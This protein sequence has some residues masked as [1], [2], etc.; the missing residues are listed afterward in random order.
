MIC[1]SN[2]LKQGR[3]GVVYLLESMAIKC[4]FSCLIYSFV[5]RVAM[6]NWVTSKPFQ[7]THRH[8]YLRA[9]TERGFTSSR[10]RE[11]EEE[12]NGAFSVWWPTFSRLPVPSL[13]SAHIPKCSVYNFVSWRTR[14]APIR[15]NFLDEAKSLTGRT[16]LFF[17]NSNG[18]WCVSGWYKGR[19]CPSGRHVITYP[20]KQFVC[21]LVF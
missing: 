5:L 4:G 11:R 15:L 17:F 9:Q 13:W 1:F 12:G 8:S 18:L 10:E 3:D 7:S 2:G 21:H 6:C 16:R 14:R 19:R 20:L